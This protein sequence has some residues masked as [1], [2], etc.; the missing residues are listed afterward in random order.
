MTVPNTDRDLWQK[1]L[2]GDSA[3]W[4]LLVKR[5]QS[6]VYAVATRAGLSMADAADCFQQTWVA[7]YE[8]RHRIQDPTRLSAWLVTTAKREAMRLRRRTLPDTGGE[9]EI[10]H[11]DRSP[12]PDEELNQIEQQAHLEMALAE[13]DPRCRQVVELFFFAPERQ[14]YDEIAA[15]LGMAMNSLGPVR[16]RCLERLKKILRKNGVI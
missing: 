6:L 14:S 11:P 5:Y 7:L 16:R 12:L 4:Q 9:A 8:N 2:A 15:S 13:L 3:A 10:D 1:T